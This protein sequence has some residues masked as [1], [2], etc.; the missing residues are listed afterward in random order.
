MNL[1]KLAPVLAL[2]LVCSSALS[3]QES[4]CTLKLAELPTTPELRGFRVGMTADEVKARLPKLQLRPADEFGFAS[5]NVFPDY[6][7]GI[8]KK[9]FGGVRTISF[10]FLDGRVSSLWLGYDKTFKWQTVNEFTPGITTALKLPNLW[11]QKFRTRLLG[12]ADFAVAIIP[13][14]ESPSI[15][16][17]DEEARGLL[18]KR[19]AAKEEAE[20]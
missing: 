7:P 16:I 8:D 5:L 14:G 10:E 12:C 3:A 2:V 1:N 17:T 15:K 20:P 13:V 9:A 6:E 4:I 18:E 11:R 19:K